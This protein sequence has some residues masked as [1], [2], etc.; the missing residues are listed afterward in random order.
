MNVSEVRKDS[1]FAVNP[2]KGQ[3][4][5][6]S[7][8]TDASSARKDAGSAGPASDG[9]SF[10]SLLGAPA[11][12]PPPTHNTAPVRDRAR[13]AQNKPPANATRSNAASPSTDDASAARERR[14][15]GTE[16]AA[17]TDGAALHDWLASLM[18][19]PHAPEQPPVPAAGSASAHGAQAADADPAAAGQWLALGQAAA[20]RPAGQ[21]DAPGDKSATEALGASADAA[22]AHAPASHGAHAAP[23]DKAELRAAAKDSPSASLTLREPGAAEAALAASA[24]KADER[25]AAARPAAPEG[26]APPPF[27]LPAAQGTP[28]PQ[29]SA[30]LAMAMPVP[31]ED[32]RF[33]HALGV[34]VSLLA[35]DGVHEAEL[36][37]N[38]ADMGPV[39]V[40]IVLEG[41]QARV[42]FGADMARTRE[43]IEH[44][45]PELAAALREAGL[46]LSGGSVSQQQARGGDDRQAS[47]DNRGTAAG[48]NSGRAN[49]TGSDASAAS[50]APA[51]RWVRS[52]GVDL[53]A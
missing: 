31:L 19:S 33:A 36:H 34:Q 2:S 49:L 6:G 7:A 46:T 23:G 24:S 43:L 15:E 32:A 5:T 10:A 40:Q 13:A 38:P 8:R 29:D 53:Y 51:R 52:G 42:E 30:P 50:S 21:T 39:S 27:V 16:D 37:L 22:T 26:S 28:A 11:E 14:T 41:T 25:L 9:E 18:H 17:G 1:P 44:S 4:S 12:A 35:R 48:T 3:A 45:L 47:G 20:G